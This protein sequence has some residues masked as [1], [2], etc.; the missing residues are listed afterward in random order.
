[1]REVKVARE[2]RWGL[3]VGLFLVAGAMGCATGPETLTGWPDVEVGTS[4]VF[5]DTGGE[6]RFLRGPDGFLYIAG[7]FETEVRVGQ[8]VLGRHS[9]AWPLEETAPPAL[10]A[11]EVVKVLSPRLARVHHHL[12]LPDVEVKELSVEVRDERAT[13][14]LGK[15][16]GE[17]KDVDFSGPT[18]L[19]LDLGGGTG[20]QQG[21]LYGILRPSEEGAGAGQL[22]RRLLGVC[23]IVDVER[24]ESTCRLWQG[25]ADYR[26]GGTIAAGQEVIFMEPTF[27]TAPGSAT[28]LVAPSGDEEVDAWLMEH[29]TNY[30]DRFPGAAVEVELYEEPVDAEDVH[31]YRWGRHLDPGGSG[32]FLGVSLVER[33]RGRHLV[34]N[35]TGL[36]SVIGSAMVAAPPEGGVD[37]GPVDRVRSD[38]MRGVAGVLMAGIMVYRGQTSMAL[39]HL[40][41]AL[42]DE[43]LRGPWRWHARD[44]YAMR[45]GALDNYEEAMWL[46]L[47]DEAVAQRR[48]DEKAYLNAL[49]TRVRLHD[50]LD[51]PEEALVAAE[52]YLEAQEEGSTA[53]L[54][55]LAMY[56]EMAAQN[57]MSDEVEAVIRALDEGCSDGCEGDLISMLAGIYWAAYDWDEVLQD[58]LVTKILGVSRMQRGA[59]MASARMF[60]GWNFLRDRN[61]TQSLIAFLEARRVYEAEGMT[62]GAARAGFYITLIQI[63]RDEPQEAFAEGVATAEYLRR[64]GDYRGVAR[65]Y[66]RLGQLFVDPDPRRQGP[67]VL[68]AGPQVLQ[69]AVQ[70]A[71]G[72]G[73]FGAASESSFTYGHFLMR[74]GQLEEAQV[75]LQHAVIYGLRTARFDTVALS[76]L[77][78]AAIARQQGDMALFE[79]EVSRAR[80]MAEAADDPVVD[81]LMESLLSPG[82]EPEDPTQLL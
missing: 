44:Q 63:G 48:E 9:G 71:L 10:F 25:H 79:A 24:D 62:Y 60:E 68:S 20:I 29:L 70:T 54:W 2:A 80:V 4:E 78:L 27:G 57:E 53:Y 69:M 75:S 74:F 35:Y 76:H 23:M 61:L 30:V 51:Q 39:M 37:M 19:T 45:W 55:A 36:G 28:L 17:V 8:V 38:R 32:V 47:E 42:G 41:E 33:D 34:L 56:G 6:P 21:D 67:E 82:Q 50:F 15:G 14:A 40:H 46:V 7:D 66:D 73:N 16:I 5:E 49:G 26:W 11:G 3:W 58:R 52:E 13:G 77:F 12:T 31:F 43:G 22:T 59:A 72:Q 81:E 65:I 1:M 64:V 18:H